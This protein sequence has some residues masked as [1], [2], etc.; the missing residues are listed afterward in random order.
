MSRWI[1]RII[2]VLVALGVLVLALLAVLPK[3]IPVEAGVATRG[4]LEV[5][6]DEDGRTR[7][8]DRHVIAAPVAGHL[9]RIELRAGDEVEAG[10]VL[11]RVAPTVSPLLDSRSRDQLEA[12]VGAANAAVRR[13]SALAE[14]ARL[15]RE[16]SVRDLDRTRVLA[17]SGALAEHVLESAEVEARALEKEADAAELGVRVAQHELQMARAALHRA[18]GKGKPGEVLEITS[19]VRGTVL[20][21]HAESEGV[22]GPGA[23]L[24]EL[25]DL[26]SLEV[27]ADLLTSDAVNVSSGDIVRLEQ[28]GGN[29]ALD[30]RVRRVEPSAFTKV[31]ALGVEEQRVLVVID[32][33][34]GETW[35]GLGDGYRVAARIVVW[36]G[37]DVLKVPANA[38]FRHRNG[39]AVFT[40]ED[41]KAAVRTIEIGH[42]TGVEVEI[43]SGIEEGARVI[44]H[45][46]DGIVDGTL[47]EAQ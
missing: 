24:L 17:Q 47:V 46:S 11:A 22:V 1:K 34:L 26:R 16:Q 38:T 14:R 6:V 4:P 33:K 42:R 15:A 19:P 12:Q 23:P 43:K 8:C 20:R 44:V 25:G 3:P 18:D 10:R 2:G 35:K 41:G 39:W 9:E 7:V 31:S 28:W 40:M 32:P 45:P 36:R 21:V 5:T 27:V 37:D 13:A 29:G 30:G